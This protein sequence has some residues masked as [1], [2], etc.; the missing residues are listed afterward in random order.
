MPLRVLVRGGGDLSSGVAYRLARAGW[1]VFITELPQPLAVRRL[2]SYSQAIYDGQITIEGV[3]GCKVDH[4]EEAV[5]LT[6]S[7]KIAVLVD[8]GAETRFQIKPNVMIDG[9]MTKSPPDLGREAAALV[10]GLGPGFQAEVNCHAV[11]E[12][13]R[14]P[15]MGR[16]YWKGTAEADTGL[17]DPVAD[18]RTE[19]V[20]RAPCDGVVR[21]HAEIGSVVESGQLVADVDGTEVRAAF[22]GSLRGIIHPGLTVPKGLKI[23]DID[24]REDRSISTHI[25]DK[26]LGV[27]GGVLEAILSRDDLRPIFW[28][29]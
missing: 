28:K 7:G 19:R 29:L 10:I 14:G 16:V 25:S 12:T 26:A 22:R 11:V 1:Q 3:T 17:P 20:L 27:S 23:G 8:P 2:V 24:P 6:Q 15:S 18:H 21:T 9:R 4:V 5:S 13:K